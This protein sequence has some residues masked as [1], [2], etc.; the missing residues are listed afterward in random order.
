MNKEQ[1][2]CFL[3]LAQTL[4]FTKAAEKLYI[5]QSAVSKQIFSLEQELGFPLFLRSKRNVLLTENGKHMMTFFQKVQ[6]EYLD[7]QETCLARIHREETIMKI[8]VIE[9]YDLSFYIGKFRETCS[10]SECRLDFD[11]ID[12]LIQKLT[13]KEF[14]MVIGQYK[15]I[16]Q[17][18]E[19][20]KANM[21]VGK[22]L[23]EIGRIIYFSVRNA[24]AKKENLCLKD[25]A[26][27]PFYI[28]K[29]KVA[30]QNA[31]NICAKENIHPIFVP[32]LHQSTIEFR[33]SSGNGFALGDEFSRIKRDSDFSYIPISHKQIVGYAYS[34]DISPKKLKY[35]E[36][37][38]K[39]FQE[40]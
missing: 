5:S 37:I 1:I 32:T 8:G 33:V 9:G 31:E 23:K 30:R 13:E 34:K 40:V 22:P 4:N 39:T 36:E 18:I 2:N 24:L 15:G 35:I 26:E 29:S 21:I 7:E 11:R 38:I 19:L 20:A 10:F 3:V 16:L 27:Q 17:A 28:G 25:F 14:D 6:R 12:A